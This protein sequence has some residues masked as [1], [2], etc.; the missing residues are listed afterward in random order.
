MDETDLQS[1][2]CTRQ[3]VP[4]QW[5]RA[6]AAITGGAES[7]GADRNRSAR[8]RN[9]VSHLSCSST[10]WSLCRLW[11]S[12]SAVLAWFALR[13]RT[14]RATTEPSL[15]EWLL[16]AWSAV[17]PPSTGSVFGLALFGLFYGGVELFIWG[18]HY[19]GFAPHADP[20]A[21]G[22]WGS[23]WSVVVVSATA[24]TESLKDLLGNSIRARPGA[25]GVLCA[26]RA[27]QTDRIFG[28]GGAGCP[29]LGLWWLDLHGALFAGLLLILLFYT[30]LP[31]GLV[32]RER[33]EHAA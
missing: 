8:E 15:G 2:A 25:L 31:L 24:A 28:L 30:S 12:V 23:I 1:A 3:S 22:F 6:P 14:T 21:W 33:S 18:G 27:R 29:G 11:S 19:F 16:G 10:S 20:S 13:K 26:A 32:G 7:R 17:G 9:W 5:M 4:E